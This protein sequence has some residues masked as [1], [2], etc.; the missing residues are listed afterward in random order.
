MSEN[1]LLI[2]FTVLLLVVIVFTARF[3]TR[4]AVL[5]L[6]ICLGYSAWLYYGL[7]YKSQYGSSLVW[8]FYLLVITAAHFLFVVGYVIR[9]LLKN[10][11]GKVS[12]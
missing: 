10:A 2:A 4:F 3:S 1:N 5:N 6:A 8:W 11:A 7:F 12:S 9:S